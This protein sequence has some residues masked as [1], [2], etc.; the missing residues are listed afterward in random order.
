MLKNVYDKLVTKVNSIDTSAFV[1]KLEIKNKIPDTSGLV[2][3]TDYNAKRN[4]IEDKIPDVGS[5]AAKTALTTVENKMH[6]VTSLVKKTNYK[7]KITEI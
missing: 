4:E 7:T 2:K 6:D 3:K 5:L 1:L